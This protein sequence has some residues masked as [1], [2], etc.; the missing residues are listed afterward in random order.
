MGLHLDQQL[1]GPSGSSAP[2]F[3]YSPDKDIC[4][5]KTQTVT[6]LLNIV[7]LLSLSLWKPSLLALMHENHYTV[8]LCSN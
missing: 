8:V 2:L 3:G 6:L 7:S 4:N 1:R 5:L